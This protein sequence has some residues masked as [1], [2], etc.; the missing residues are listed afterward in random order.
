MFVNYFQ[1]YLS[2]FYILDGNNNNIML[3]KNNIFVFGH[4]FYI[5]YMI[6]LLIIM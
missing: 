1:E 2:N 5:T 4:V 3:P 6:N